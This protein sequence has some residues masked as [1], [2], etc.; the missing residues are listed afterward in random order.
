MERAELRVDTS[1]GDRHQHRRVI[2]FPRQPAWEG[3]RPT[4]V[5][6]PRAAEAFLLDRV[7]AGSAVFMGTV[8]RRGRRYQCYRVFHSDGEKG[9]GGSTM[10]YH[11]Q[12]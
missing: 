1:G 4:R 7:S 9:E 12:R 6:S 2:P 11:P 3:E 10:I 5:M 8:E